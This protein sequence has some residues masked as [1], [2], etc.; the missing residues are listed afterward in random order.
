M[1]SLMY[2][3]RGVVEW[4]EA[5]APKLT[6]GTDVLIRPI[7]ASF[8]DLDRAIAHGRTPLDGP[9]AIGHE[10]VGEV[11]DLGDAAASTLT[12][13]Q[14]VVVPF[15]V[16][17][18]TCDR[19]VG[20]H[21]VSCRRTPWLAS[22]GNPVGGSWGGLF[23][24]LVRVPYGATSVIPLPPLVTPLLAASVGDNMT[25]AYYGIGPYL[26]QDRGASV[27]V[28]GGTPSLGLLVTMFAVL[29]GSGSVTYVDN[30][31]QRCAMAGTLGATVVETDLPER[32]EGDFDLVVEAHGDFRRAP[33]VAV[34]SVRPGGRCHLR[35]VYFGDVAI[36]F[37]EASEKGVTIEVGLPQVGVLAPR[38]LDILVSA[39]AAVQ[40]LL[41]AHHDWV[42]APN[43]ILDTAPGKPV[44]VRS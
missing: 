9:F 23:D 19:C 13:G 18:G 4:R 3:Q 38:V 8:C 12:I 40:P 5:P 24:D 37:L 32:V 11:V 16:A 7:A 43:A 27:L 30:D 2:A 14:N 1:K 33:A 44:F 20:G 42:D 22:Y 6:A 17:C 25:D 35:C 29:L 39:G 36:P 15:Y 21:P 34:R 10:A 41:R 31:P 28:L 26:E